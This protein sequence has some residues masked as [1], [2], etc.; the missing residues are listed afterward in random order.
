MQSP[1]A[2]KIN[3]FFEKCFSYCT[4]HFI[5][6]FSAATADHMS[7]IRRCTGKLTQSSCILKI[8]FKHGCTTALW[9]SSFVFL[10]NFSHYISWLQIYSCLTF[11]A[12]TNLT[13]LQGQDLW[14]LQHKYRNS[15]YLLIWIILSSASTP[16]SGKAVKLHQIWVSHIPVTKLQVMHCLAS[17]LPTSLCFTANSL[18]SGGGMEDAMPWIMP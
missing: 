6:C 17:S 7:D 11:V 3:N 14:G 15:R 8:C 1:T 9:I 5:A 2:S 16:F 4:S 18:N 10:A 12:L 13:E